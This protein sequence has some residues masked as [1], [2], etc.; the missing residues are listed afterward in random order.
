M[1]P[2]NTYDITERSYANAAAFPALQHTLQRH[3]R[4]RASPHTPP[5]ERERVPIT[6]ASMS[7]VLRNPSEQDP[8]EPGQ[9]ACP[10]LNTTTTHR[11]S[12]D[13]L[14]RLNDE[15]QAAHLRC[16]ASSAGLK[17]ATPVARLGALVHWV[18]KGNGVEEELR[19]ALEACGEGEEV[20]HELRWLGEGKGRVGSMMAILWNP[21]RV[22]KLVGG[23][24]ELG[25]GQQYRLSC[26]R[27][28]GRK[29]RTHTGKGVLPPALKS[30][31][32]GA[33]AC[34]G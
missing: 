17:V 28:R 18:P 30:A 32:G 4:A 13:V 11:S 16:T 19:A 3:Q 24:G 12:G 9:L 10:A 2:S 15:K 34:P 21:Q 6:H 8:S 20:V 22:N 29:G 7:V 27:V 1:A 25:L 14:L 31:G 23:N 33:P 5:A 26:E